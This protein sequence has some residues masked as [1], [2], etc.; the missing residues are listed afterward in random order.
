[1]L[2]QHD[3]AELFFLDHG[4]SLHLDHFEDGEEGDDHGVARRASL[5]ETDEVDGVVVAGQDLRAELAIIC[6]TVNCSCCSSMRET[7]FAPLT[8]LAER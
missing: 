4:D 7:S 1:M 8:E 6:A 2:A 3:F 5:E